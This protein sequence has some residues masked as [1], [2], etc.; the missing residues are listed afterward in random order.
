MAGGPL[1]FP[2]STAPGPWHRGARL[3]HRRSRRPDRVSTLV[4]PGER[5]ARGLV[6]DISPVRRQCNPCRWP[7]RRCRSSTSRRTSARW[8]ARS[9]ARH[10]LERRGQ[11]CG[12]NQVSGEGIQRLSPSPHGPLMLLSPGDEAAWI[13]YPRSLADLGYS[14]TDRVEGRGRVRGQ[15]RIVRGFPAGGQSGA[16]RL[17]GRSTRGDKGLLGGHPKARGRRPRLAAFP[18]PVRGATRS[19][20]SRSSPRNWSGVSLGVPPRGTGSARVRSFSGNRVLA[21]TGSPSPCP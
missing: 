14:R 6:D 9:E 3:R 4:V 7:G 16:A 15:R 11:S 8:P 5:D 18:A 17:L 13:P 20:D 19:A 10:A 21:S 12:R 1:L 2:I